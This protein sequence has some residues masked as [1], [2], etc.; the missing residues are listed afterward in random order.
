MFLVTAA[1]CA[2]EEEDKKAKEKEITAQYDQKKI[3]ENKKAI[4]VQLST[5]TTGE[6][7]VEI[8][9]KTSQT[10]IFFEDLLDQKTVNKDLIFERVNA[11]IKTEEAITSNSVLHQAKMVC[12]K[13][14]KAFLEEYEKKPADLATKI[15]V[16]LCHGPCEVTATLFRTTMDTMKLEAVLKEIASFLELFKTE[17]VTLI[18]ENYVTDHNDLV[19]AYKKSGIESMILKKTDWDPVAKNGWPTLSWMQEHNRRIVIFSDSESDYEFLSGKYIAENR[20]GETD[21]SNLNTSKAIQEVPRSKSYRTSKRYLMLVNFFPTLPIDMEVLQAMK[22]KEI[23]G[24]KPTYDY[25]TM[26]STDI[27]KLVDAIV[28]KGFVDKDGKGNSI[29]VLYQ[30]ADGSIHYPN[31]IALDYVN[32]G[33]PILFINELNDLQTAQAVAAQKKVSDEK[34][35]KDVSLE[36]AL[37][38]AAGALKIV[39]TVVK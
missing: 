13:D 36:Q 14:L 9:Q 32:K 8:A 3:K 12:L 4:D 19:Q 5:I 26:N 1:L 39:K 17:V 23:T 20:Y 16:H 6:D 35:G 2:T 7:T 24:G 10:K 34:T 29:R 25:A 18:L 38:E 11:F 21:V 31:F 28:N 15:D 37:A 30:N 27:R 22:N 33:N